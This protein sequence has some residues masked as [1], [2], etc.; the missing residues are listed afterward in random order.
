MLIEYL[1]DLNTSRSLINRL[2]TPKRQICGR[3]VA[4]LILLN[5]LIFI[6]CPGA[7]S[8]RP[9]LEMGTPVVVI[10]PGHGGNDTGAK[11]PEGTL[12]KSVTLDLARLI[13]DQ[14]KN[15]CQVILTRS[16]DYGMKLAER[17]AVAN[18]SAADIFISLHT[19]SSFIS[20][21]NGS[22]VYFYQPFTGSSLSTETRTPKTLTDSSLPLS[23]DQI[24]LK[25]QTSSEK[26]A[27][28]I[29]HEINATSP[30]PD[31]KVQGAPLLVL[32]GADMPAVAIEIGN[33]S[34]PNEE[35][36]MHD[37]EFLTRIARAIARGIDAFLTQKQK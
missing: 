22:A 16:D 37:P 12:E 2:C 7:Y 4:S 10:D 20:S 14:L 31:T 29:Q 17:T 6:L 24:Q 1:R 35:K 13:E 26:L 11:G 36:M 28:L 21:I 3:Y 30:S 27:K 34:N 23:W 25:Y 19:G 33:L 8:S 5:L 32:E 9:I 15:S 18:R